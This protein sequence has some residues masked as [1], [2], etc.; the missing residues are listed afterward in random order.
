MKTYISKL[1]HFPDS[2]L[3]RGR[4]LPKSCLD[5]YTFQRMC[6]ISF[7]VITVMI[8]KDPGSAVYGMYIVIFISNTVMVWYY[9]RKYHDS[10]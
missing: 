4:H 5:A 7:L 6:G 10:H 2:N 9:L 1:M 8:S 3:L